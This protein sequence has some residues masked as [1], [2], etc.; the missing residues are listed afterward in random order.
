MRGKFTMKVAKTLVVVACAGLLSASLFGSASFARAQDQGSAGDGGGHSAASVAT[1]PD[2]APPID[3]AGCWDGSSTVGTLEDNSFG[4]GYGWIGIIQNG[5]NIESGAHGSFYEFVWDSGNDWAYGPF[6][7]KASASGFTTM[8]TLKGKCKVK[9]I[10]HLGSSDDIVG[11][12]E[13]TRLLRH[14]PVSL[15]APARASHEAAPAL[16]F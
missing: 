1:Q 2:K 13:Y 15:I 9:F 8:G 6:K 11:T 16:L 3:V 10:G 7:G 4:S 14:H 12:Y 5:K